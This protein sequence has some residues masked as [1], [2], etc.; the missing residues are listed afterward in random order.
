MGDSLVFFQEA[1]NGLLT[2]GAIFAIK[3]ADFMSILINLLFARINAPH[4][5]NY[6]SHSL[7]VR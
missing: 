4:L 5:D 2:K 1:G 3:L 7:E 6:L